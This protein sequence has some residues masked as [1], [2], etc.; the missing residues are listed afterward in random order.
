MRRRNSE[1]ARAE[2]ATHRIASACS[3]G[4]HPPYGAASSAA[5]VGLIRSLTLMIHEAPR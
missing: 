5:G 2:G 4:L 3:G 1:N